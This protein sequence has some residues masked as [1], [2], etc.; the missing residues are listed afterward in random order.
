MKAAESPS[1][2]N[3]ARMDEVTGGDKEFAIELVDLFLTDSTGIIE[4]LWGLLDEENRDIFRREAHKLK[5]SAANLGANSLAQLS[6]EME[7]QALA[8]KKPE[9]Q[10]RVK[11]LD[12]EFAR[13][14]R[15]L[16]EYLQALRKKT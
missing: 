10:E 14:R 2:V 3:L 8:L 15:Q 11:Q 6:G 12:E 5:G 1:P 4:Q 13:V 16:E 7:Q 9:L